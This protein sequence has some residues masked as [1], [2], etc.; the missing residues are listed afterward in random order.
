MKKNVPKKAHPFFG[1]ISN[2]AIIVSF[3]SFLQ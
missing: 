2:Q 1:T 3:W